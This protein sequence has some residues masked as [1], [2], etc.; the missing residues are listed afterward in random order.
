VSQISPPIRIV[1][2]CAIGFL[3]AYM[4]FLRPKTEVTP[5][6]DPAPNVQTS[7]PAVSQPGKV[8]EAAQ[9][10]V[11]AANGQLQSQESVDGVDAEES[12]AGTSTTT[13]T[14]DP[15]ATGAAAATAADLAGLPKPVAKAIRKHQVLVLLFWNGKS[16]DDKAVHAAVKKVDRWDGRVSVQTASIRKISQYGRIARGVDVEQSPT[17]VVA[18]T[19]LRADTLVGYVDTTTID[20]SVVDALRNSSGL[21]TDA[22]LKSVDKV[23]VQNSNRMNAIP[24]YYPRGNVKKLDTRL[25]TYD[26]AYQD[27]IAGFGSVKASKKWKAFKTAAVKDLAAGEVVVAQYAA[28]IKPSTSFGDALAAE[29]TFQTAI[30]PISKRLNHRFDS[31]GLFRCGSAF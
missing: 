26:R 28:K 19:E 2:V 13:K 16:A 9:G 7:A 17:V 14:T 30:A 8:A 29:G 1:L 5:P 20:Q 10:A 27:F 21:F 11:A 3:G 15:A 23:C 6:A 24:N 4:L 18:D 22:Y 12:A 25:S 31:Q